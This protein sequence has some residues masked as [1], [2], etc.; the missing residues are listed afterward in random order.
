MSIDIERDPRDTMNNIKQISDFL[1]FHLEQAAHHGFADEMVSDE[2]EGLA[3]I[4]R[5]VGR[6]A[7]RAEDRTSELMTQA[8]KDD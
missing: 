5:W 1:A 3:Q 6:R 4:M 2:A 7:K 8:K